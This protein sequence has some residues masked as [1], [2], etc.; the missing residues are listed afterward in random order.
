[1]LKLNS[2]CTEICAVGEIA[3]KGS[4]NLENAMGAILLA[5]LSGVAPKD[6]RQVL[7]EFPGVEHR[8]EPVR[9]LHDILYINDSK[10]T[11]PDS[12]IKALQAYERPVVIILGGKNKGSDFTQLA[13]LVKEKVKKAVVLGQAKPAIIDALE[14]A[15]FHDYI[16]KDTFEEAVTEAAVQADPGDIVLL[17][18]ACASW[19]MFSSYEERGNLF[20]ELVQQL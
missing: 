19:D 3:I 17:S 6:I 15:G 18:P 16:E 7:M 5:Y 10:G 11:N 20:K 2:V 8:L 4:H 1:M 13:Q 12:T 9:T 14:K